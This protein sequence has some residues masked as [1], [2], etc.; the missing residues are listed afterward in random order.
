MNEPLRFEFRIT[1]A[2]GEEIASDWTTIAPGA[3]DQWGGCETVD[4]H[5]ASTL[6]FVRKKQHDH[7]INR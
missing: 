5:V 3:V 1:N 2:D 7:P 4:M 6:R